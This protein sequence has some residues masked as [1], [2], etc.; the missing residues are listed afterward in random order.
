M[1]CGA[2]FLHKPRAAQP[3]L[4]EGAGEPPPGDPGQCVRQAEDVQR[5]GRQLGLVRGSHALRHSPGAAS[6]PAF[7]SRLNSSLPG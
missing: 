6:R 7:T 4:Y 5:A 2:G 3:G 1:I